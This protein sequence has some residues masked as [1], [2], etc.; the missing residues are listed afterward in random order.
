TWI[1]FAIFTLIFIVI[2]VIIWLLNWYSIKK[3]IRS[4]NQQIKK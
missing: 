3:E 1:N 2:Y 4:I